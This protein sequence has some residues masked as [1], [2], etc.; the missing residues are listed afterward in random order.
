MGRRLT[1]VRDEADRLVTLRQ[2]SNDYGEQLVERSLASLRADRHRWKDEG[3]P[4]AVDKRGNADV[5]DRRQ[6][7]DFYAGRTAADLVEASA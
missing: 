5:F 7:T 4:A 3:F 2:A 6:L 1:V